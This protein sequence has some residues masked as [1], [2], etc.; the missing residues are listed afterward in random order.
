MA[1]TPILNK[2]RM[3]KLFSPLLILL[4]SFSAIAEEGTELKPRESKKRVLRHERRREKGRINEYQLEFVKPYTT[5]QVHSEPA[6]LGDVLSN[7]SHAEWG[8]RFTYAPFKKRSMS[9]FFSAAYLEYGGSN[10]SS[11]RIEGGGAYTFSKLLYAFFGL[12][13]QKFLNSETAQMIDLGYGVQGLVGMQ[14]SQQFGVK[15]GYTYTKFIEKEYFNYKINTSLLSPEI[16]L[17]WSF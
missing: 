16:G 10:S 2:A 17:Y 14:I 5:Y 8:L 12:Q 9:Y 15:L 3:K 1:T 13:L 7:N 11:L 4:I 6:G